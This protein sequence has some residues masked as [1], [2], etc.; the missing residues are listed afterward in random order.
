MAAAIGHCGFSGK[1][2]THVIRPVGRRC[3][4][5]STRDL[6]G[7]VFRL[8]YREPRGSPASPPLVDDF[9]RSTRHAPSGVVPTLSGYAFAHARPTFTSAVPAN[10]RVRHVIRVPLRTCDC[11]G[12]CV[13]DVVHERHGF[14]AVAR[15]RVAAHLVPTLVVQRLTDDRTYENP[16]GP[17]IRTFFGCVVDSAGAVR[18]PVPVWPALPDP[19]SGE[20]VHQK[21]VPEPLR[22]ARVTKHRNHGA[23]VAAEYDTLVRV[24]L[25][26]G[27]RLKPAQ[28]QKSCARDGAALALAPPLIRYTYDSATLHVIQ[29]PREGSLWQS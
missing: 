17:T 22:Q 21:V 2:D 20:R 9:L 3:S 19:T 12:L 24:H 26:P 28:R 5:A 11:M 1:R 8:L 6:A 7:S 18:I 25:K 15:S 23:K 4:P 27:Q 16:I 29:Y 14:T 13:P 10:V